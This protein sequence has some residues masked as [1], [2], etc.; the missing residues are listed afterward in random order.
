M[1]LASAR[2]LSRE[3]PSAFGWEVPVFAGLSDRRRQIMD[4]LSVVIFASFAFAGLMGWL[5]N[6]GNRR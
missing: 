2:S 5:G 6:I 1:G 3:K 4:Y